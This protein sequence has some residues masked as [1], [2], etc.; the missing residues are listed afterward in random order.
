MG[1]KIPNVN[2]SKVNWT[3]SYKTRSDIVDPRGKWSY[4]NE[5]VKVIEQMK[6]YATGKT[7]KVAWFSSSCLPES[8]GTEYVLELQKYIEVDIYG[9]CGNHKCPEIEDCLDE[10]AKEHKFYLAFED[11]KCREFISE[12]FFEHSLR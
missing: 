5:H 3:V 10:I 2:G 6:N 12:I 8:Y 4:Y 1:S 11:V 7:K 9:G